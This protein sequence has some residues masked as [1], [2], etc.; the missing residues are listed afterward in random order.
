MNQNQQLEIIKK[1]QSGDTKAKQ[2]ASNKLWPYHSEWISKVVGKRMKQKAGL[3]EDEM[4]SEACIAF[5]E[6]VNRYEI[7]SSDKCSLKTYASYWINGALNTYARSEM[8]SNFV[9]PRCKSDVRSKI[10]SE[11]AGRNSL[12]QKSLIKLSKE[13]DIAESRVRELEMFFCHSGIE[14]FDF[15][16]I[17]PDTFKSSF[18]ESIDECKVL[19]VVREFVSQ[20]P[21]ETRKVLNRRWLIDK[22]IPY[23]KLATELGNSYETNRQLEKQAFRL[24]MTELKGRAMIC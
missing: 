23:M 14:S 3:N 12:S 9:V 19:S 15:S 7:T 16:G 20:Q 8:Y 18:A 1:Y 4:R 13:F 6:A 5:F 2:E 24:L 11:L 21:T 10:F 17:E 22:K